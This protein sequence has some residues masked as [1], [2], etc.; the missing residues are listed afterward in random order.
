MNNLFMDNLGV[1]FISDFPKEAEQKD[2][3]NFFKGYQ[4]V[5]YREEFS[6]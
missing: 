3:E 6:R 1:L 5:N 2:I 4:L